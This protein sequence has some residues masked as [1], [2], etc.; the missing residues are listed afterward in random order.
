MIKSRKNY[1][2]AGEVGHNELDVTFSQGMDKSVYQLQ[3][4][5]QKYIFLFFFEK[6]LLPLLTRD[7]SSLISKTHL[8][9]YIF[10]LCG[11]T[12]ERNSLCV[13]L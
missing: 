11:L 8:R 5:Q 2:S 3:R 12:I 9:F 13:L 10:F 4:L 1:N 6:I 7:T